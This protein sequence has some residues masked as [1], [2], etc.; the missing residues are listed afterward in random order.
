MLSPAESTSPIRI[1][2][3]GGRPLICE[4]QPPPWCLP[5]GCLCARRARTPS[6]TILALHQHANQD[7][8]RLRRLGRG[9]KRKTLGKVTCWT[10]LRRLKGVRNFSVLLILASPARCG[11]RAEEEDQQNVAPQSTPHLRSYSLVATSESGC[12][13]C[14]K[15]FVCRGSGNG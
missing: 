11:S 3:T 2:S 12:R 10:L 6:P 4:K 1:E 8:A 13:G 7:G 14:T 9:V 15:V 5:R